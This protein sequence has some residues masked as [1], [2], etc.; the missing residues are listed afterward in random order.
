[1]HLVRI[2]IPF[3]HPRQN[4]LYLLS[5]ADLAPYDTMEPD[6]P[7]RVEGSRRSLRMECGITDSSGQY[8]ITQPLFREVVKEFSLP[9]LFIFGRSL[10]DRLFYFQVRTNHPDRWQRRGRTLPWR[11][12]RRRAFHQLRFCSTCGGNGDLG[13]ELDPGSR[14]RRT[15]SS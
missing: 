3:C 10:S 14:R 11:S 8:R 12:A 15:V 5:I 9:L 7:N 4:E 1:M 2:P 6:S 13:I